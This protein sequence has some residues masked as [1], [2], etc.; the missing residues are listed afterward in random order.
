[1]VLCPVGQWIKRLSGNIKY[2]HIWFTVTLF[3]LAHTFACHSMH[4]IFTGWKAKRSL[5]G[6]MDGKLCIAAHAGIW[7]LLASEVSPRWELNGI[8]RIAS[9][10]S[11][12]LF[13][14]IINF[15]ILITD[16][17]NMRCSRGKGELTNN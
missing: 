9:H 10:G 8:L 17:T 7:L 12:Y 2:V 6:E 14:I 5:V 3:S 13:I 16:H 11:I 4:C 1:M 15:F